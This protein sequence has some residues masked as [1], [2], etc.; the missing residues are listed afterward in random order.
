MAESDTPP[1]ERDADGADTRSLG[2]KQLEHV[3]LME[4]VA[5]HPTHPTFAE[6][7]LAL[8]SSRVELASHMVEDSLWAL[9]ALRP[10]PAKR[11][12]PRTDT[13]GSSRRRGHPEG[14]TCSASGA[15]TTIIAWAATASEASSQM[16][17]AALSASAGSGK[18]P[19]AGLFLRAADGIRTHDLLHGN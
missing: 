12:D 2:D 10:G 16:V 19:G 8:S 11:G 9:K 13:R 5:L 7:H 4:I 1:R 14:L 15:T 18:A 6:L 17:L 3:V